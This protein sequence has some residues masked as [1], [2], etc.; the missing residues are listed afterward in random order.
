[1]SRGR[2]VGG[3]PQQARGGRARNTGDV[4]AAVSGVRA[5]REGASVVNGVKQKSVAGE[6]PGHAV[7][8]DR[9]TREAYC[10][11][12]RRRTRASAPV[13]NR[14]SEAGSGVFTR[15]F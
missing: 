5:N 10:F 14:N 11:F 7:C 6:N 9:G 4:S 13:P 12:R 1:M 3:R 2:R 15:R 8:L